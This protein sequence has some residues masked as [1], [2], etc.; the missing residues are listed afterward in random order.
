MDA[1]RFFN[2]CS[3]VDGDGNLSN[4]LIELARIQKNL[5]FN[6]KYLDKS[7]RDWNE[8]PFEEIKLADP[9]SVPSNVKFT[10]PNI[11]QGEYGA[12]LDMLIESLKCVLLQLDPKEKYLFSHSSGSDSRIISGVMSQMKKSGLMDFENVIFYCWGRPE[13]E[14]FRE[15][16][17]AGGW[18]NFIIN[19]DSGPNA[20]D[21]GVQEFSVDGWNPYVSQ[22]K[23]WKGVDPSEF[24]LL[25]G[26]EGETFFLPY[27]KWVHAR[28]FFV[29]RG[30]SIHRLCKVFKGGFFPFLSYEMLEL[31]M[32]MPSAWRNVKDTRINRDKVRTDLVDRLGLLN[33]PV[34]NA[35]YN[36]NVTKDRKM[37][38]MDLYNKSRFKI[39]YDVDLD[40]ED[41]F[42]NANGWNSRAW[43]FAVTVYENLM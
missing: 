16:M 27:E 21:V 10:Q 19:D 1:N 36:L 30:E 41:L 42:K 13:E 7:F 8:T 17:K 39:E 20:F 5:N 33:I 4:S 35:Y 26:A 28:S 38:M 40:F 25:A 32:A 6:K 24:I 34:D 29:E 37:Q 18:E 3:F 9:E 15:I 14:S 23:F 22:M 11:F 12:Y 43:S 2:R 31:T